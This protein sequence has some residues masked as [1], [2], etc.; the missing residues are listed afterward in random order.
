MLDLRTPSPVDRASPP[1]V[2]DPRSPGDEEGEGESRP[3][4][5]PSGGGAWGLRALLQMKRAAG[6]I[7]GAG[8]E[9]GNENENEEGVTQGKALVQRG[10]RPRRKPVM[11]AGG[12]L[13]VAKMTTRE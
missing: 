6:A 10:S 11:A 9:D 1:G 3:P 12:K 4:L 5:P 7:A 8:A 13:R 2:G